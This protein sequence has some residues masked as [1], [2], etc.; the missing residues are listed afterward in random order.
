MPKKFK[1]DEYDVK[2]GTFIS[3]KNKDSIYEIDDRNKIVPFF[4]GSIELHIISTLWTLRIGVAYEKNI[5]RNAYANRLYSKKKLTQ[6]R[7]KL[8]KKYYHSYNAWRDNAIEQAKSL[9]LTGHNVAILNLDIRSY[10]H[11]INM[12]LSKLQVSRNNKWL[13]LLLIK[14]HKEY[15]WK[16]TSDNILSGPTEI[17]PIGLVSSSILANFYL[18][19]LDEN[20]LAYARPSFYGRYVDDFLFVFKDPQIDEAQSKIIS[21]F[22]DKNIVARKPARLTEYINKTP[23]GEYEIN[24]KGN[25]LSFQLEKVKLYYFKKEDSIELLEEFKREIEKNSSEFKIQLEQEELKNPFE[26][27]VYKITYSDTINKLRSIDSFTPNK[28]GASKQLTKIIN[29]TKFL[30]QEEELVVHEISPRINNYFVGRRCLELYQLWEK[31]FAYFVVNND[32]KGLIRFSNQLINSVSKVRVNIPGFTKHQNNRLSKTL[33]EC[34]LTYLKNG[35]STAAALDI[36]FFD[37]NIVARS[38][39]ITGIRSRFLRSLLSSLVGKI[40]ATEIKRNALKIIDA[41]L[42]NHFFAAYPLFNYAKQPNNFPFSGKTIKPTTNFDFDWKKIELSPRYI[43]FDEVELFNFIKFNWCK[44]PMPA[45]YHTSRFQYNR[46]LHLQ[47]NANDKDSKKNSRFSNLTFKKQKAF[48]KISINS[49]APLT[50]I[51][52]GLANLKLDKQNIAA[53]RDEPVLNLQKL[54]QINK[55]LNEAIRSNTHVVVFPEVSI[56]LQWVSKLAF[57]A[58]KNNIAIV[59]GVEHFTNKKQAFNY[60]CT[61]LPFEQ[62]GYCHSLVDFRVK[63]DYSPAELGEIAKYNLLPPDSSY[64][65]LRLF[66]W[67]GIYFSVFNCF[68]LADIEKRSLF[69]GKVDV[70]LAVEY[71]SDTTYFSNINESFARDIHAY[72]IQVNSS[73]YGDSRITLPKKT[74]HRDYVKLKGGENISLIVGDLDIKALRSFQQLT[75]ADQ[76]IDKTFKPTPPNFVFQKIEN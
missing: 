18:R 64:E 8:F 22:I 1:N 49:L 45:L 30:S 4:K 3:N 37:T 29:T 56:P 28:F 57:Y 2:D 9:H 70:V 21:D 76:L 60:V 7:L 66:F 11:S 61:I 12:D 35:Y 10:Y 24:I 32:S 40:K 43:N 71:N 46:K 75:F 52:V 51:R 59:C 39:R 38:T 26:N 50:M 48:Y 67:R 13:N 72:T 58:R 6:N 53:I 34:M 25:G 65:K 42:F 27:S 33:Y 44:K 68:E 16:L 20:I 31:A 55:A 36:N 62:N 73:D 47:L 54:N 17:L 15:I 63:K 69:R 74:E 5:P 19:D 41:N 23:T 14:I